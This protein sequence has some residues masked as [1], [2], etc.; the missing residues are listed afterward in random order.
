VY[1]FVLTVTDSL[2]VS[3]TDIANINYFGQ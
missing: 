2:G 3:A 1:S